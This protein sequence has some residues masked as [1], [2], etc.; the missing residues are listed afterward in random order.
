MQFENRHDLFL[1]LFIPFYGKAIQL[2]NQQK[3]SELN[4]T[5]TL[6]NSFINLLIK[7]IFMNEKQLENT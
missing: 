4:L 1:S 5:R 3:I 2:R 6:Y 7:I